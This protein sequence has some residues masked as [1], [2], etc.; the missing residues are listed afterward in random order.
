MM[1]VL[2]TDCVAFIVANAAAGGVL[3]PRRRYAYSLA[4]RCLARADKE[5]ENTPEEMQA[6]W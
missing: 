4:K 2:S 6:G 5:D 3:G 1:W